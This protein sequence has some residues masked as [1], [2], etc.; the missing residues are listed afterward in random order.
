MIAVLTP[1]VLEFIPE[2]LEDG[3]LYISETYGTAVHK[4]CCG[5][6]QKVVTPLSPTGW[7]LIVEGEFV[8]LY[9]SIGNWGYPCRSHY[10]IRRNEVHW[11][12]QM[13]QHEIEASR[14]YDAKVKQRYFESDKAAAGPARADDRGAMLSAWERLKKWLFG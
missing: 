11:S 12:Y 6:G 5:C 14:R 10:W 3:K 4:C 13:S 2:V 8:S 9:P 7:K 1:V